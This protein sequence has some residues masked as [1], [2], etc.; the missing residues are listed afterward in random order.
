MMGGLPLPHEALPPAP[1]FVLGQLV[2]IE[3]FLHFEEERE[4]WL[5]SL[6]VMLADVRR[7]LR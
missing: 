1:Y 7:V 5:V 3:L 2:Y 4:H 6:E